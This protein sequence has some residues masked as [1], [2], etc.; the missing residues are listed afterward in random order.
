MAEPGEA[1]LLVVELAV[2]QLPLPQALFVADQVSKEM[3][4]VHLLAAAVDRPALATVRDD[5]SADGLEEPVDLGVGLPQ[6]ILRV[7]VLQLIVEPARHFPP[8]ALVLPRL[9]EPEVQVR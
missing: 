1:D 8:V 5:L 2:A 3:A 6:L 9:R 4:A 7:L